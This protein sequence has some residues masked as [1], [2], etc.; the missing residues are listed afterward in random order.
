M[1][2]LNE[3]VGGVA[4]ALA[5][6]VAVAVESTDAVRRA[7]ALVAGPE[8]M[9]T[10]RQTVLLFAGALTAGGRLDPA[11]YSAVS[12]LAVAAVADGAPPEAIRTMIHAAAQVAVDRVLKAWEAEG[13]RAAGADLRAALGLVGD[14]EFD[15][16]CSFE[17]R[18]H[19]TE[20]DGAGRERRVREAFLY[21]VLQGPI[22]DPRATA[23]RAD[24]LGIDLA[25]P[26]GVIALVDPLPDLPDRTGPES[27]PAGATFEDRVMRCRRGFGAPAASPVFLE[28]D[29]AA[30]P[31]A[32]VVV[33]AWAGSRAD[34]VGA[35]LVELCTETRLLSIR[36]EA[37][38]LAAASLVF[39]RLRHAATIIERCAPHVG[40]A[41][42]LSALFP[43]RLVEEL[44]ASEAEELMR[45]EVGP[46]MAKARGAAER[47]NTWKLLVRERLTVSETAAR[48][49]VAESTIRKRRAVIERLLG[50]DPRDDLLRAQAASYLL[51]LYA[52]ELEPPGHGWWTG[53]HGASPSPSAFLPRSGEVPASPARVHP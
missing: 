23:R 9:A 21:R 47:L 29:P 17:E 16:L 34:V 35:G 45:G 13:R 27:A 49:N 53:G 30:P 14:C 40:P 31:L 18:L 42:T 48:L 15:L 38:D 51:E 33:P 20:A 43:Y 50:R 39:H 24:A 4:D 37:P 52:D 6:Q 25:L 11:E 22:G 12:E 5:R 41:A 26:L 10:V 28:P 1:T 46:L 8:F 32:V 44:T 3:E 19:H 36:A 2:A 7:P